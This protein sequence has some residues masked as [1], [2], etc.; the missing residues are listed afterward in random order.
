MYAISFVFLR[1]VFSIFIFISLINS[2]FSY[3]S[4]KYPYAFKLSNKN[5]FVIHE[6]GISICDKTFTRI[7][8]NATKFSEQEKIKSNAALSK[9]TSIFCETYFIICLI[10]DKIYIFDTEGSL[11]K[12]STNTIASWTV[13]YYSLEY[14]SYSRGYLYFVIGFISS[15]K[16]YLYYYEFYVSGQT[17][18]VSKLE[19]K[20][21]YDITS[22]ELSCHY[23]KHDNLGRYI[24]TC[25]YGYSNYIVI[26]YFDV[27]DDTTIVKSQAINTKYIDAKAEVKYIKGTLLIPEGNYK[28]LYVGYIT[29]DGTPYHWRYNINYDID[30]YKIKKFDYSIC[31]SIHHG[32]KYIYYPEKAELL[33]TCLLESD[34]WT[35]PKANILVEFLNQNEIQ[36]NYTYKFNNCNL[37][38]YS[39]IYLDS[40]HEY[41]IISDAECSNELIPFEILFEKHNEVATTM[42]EKPTTIIPEPTTIIPEP[43]TIITPPTTIIKE[44]TTIIK[45]PTTIITPP[46]TI[47][48]ELTTIITSPSTIIKEPTTIIP[49]PTTIVNKQTTIIN[50]PSTIIDKQTTIITPPSTILN[51]PTTIIN[52]PTTIINEPTTIIPKQTTIIDEPTTI[53]TQNSKTEEKEISDCPQLEKC[54]ICNEESFNKNLCIKCNEA[55]GYYFLNKNAISKEEIGDQYID[56]VNSDTKPSKFYFNSENEDYRLCFETCATCDTGGD[57]EI[58][59]CT[60]CELNYIFK[61]DKI[62]E[63]NCVMEC[64][65]YY[66][67]NTNDQYKCTKGEYCPL[68]YILLIKDK[69]KCTNDCKNDDP[70]RYQYDNHCLKECPINT[71]A[72]GYICKDKDINNSELTET[73]H[74]L[75]NRNITEDEMHQLVLNYKDNFNY[76]SNHI[77]IYKS[78]NYT[79]AIYK[80]SE[81][82]SSLSLGI[83]KINFESCYEK[84]KREYNISDDLITLLESE[85]INSQFDKIEIFS[86]YNPTTGEKIIFNDL[87]KSEPVTVNEDLGNKI[88]NIDWFMDLADQGI[89][90]FN[91]NSDFFTDL[92]YH[93]KSPIDGKDIPLKERFKLF[94]PNVSLCEKGCS[95]KGINTTTNTSIC[96]CTLNNIINNNFLTDNIFFQSTMAE[97]KTLIQ[98]SNIE[99]L[100]CYKDL[101]KGEF[102]RTNYGSFIILG[103]LLIQIILTIIYYKKYIFSMRKYLFNLIKTYLSYLSNKGIPS[104]KLDNSLD[105]I[106]DKVLKFQANP[107]KRSSKKIITNTINNNESTKSFNSNSKIQRRNPNQNIKSDV[108]RTFIESHKGSR[109]E[110]LTKQRGI[111]HNHFEFGLISKDQNLLYIGDIIDI[112]MEEY[113]K[114]DPDDMDYDNAIKRDTRTFCV[115]LVDNVKTDL[116]ILNIFCNYEQLNP[117][118][119]KFLLFI[120]NIDL[121]FFVNG[122][123]F[124]EDYLSELLY[125]KNVNFL[126]Y[127][128][129]FMER[130]YYITLVGII[131]GYVMNCFFFEERIIKKLFKREKNNLL[132]LQYEMS[133]LIKNIKNRYNSFIIICFVVAIFVWYYVFCFNNIYPSM[134]KEW[135]ITSVILIFVMQFIYFL[136]LLLETII[137][138][139][140]IKCKSERLF[141]FSQFLS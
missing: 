70:Y 109:N 29:S 7:I 53:I 127:A 34:T 128:S 24:V 84:I 52:E 69:K 110:L 33:Y 9:V 90:V 48:K 50:E 91:P 72:D 54:E 17:F 60:T 26:D 45:E 61:P 22:E 86:V 82:I 101:S 32:F 36:T 94:F 63:I 98:D 80:N 11:V 46:T 104:N 125:D 117:W 92:C 59:N 85:K 123:F 15:K 51:Q 47:I 62:P 136:K 108:R 120:L 102:Y 14:L 16:L 103:L 21:S 138:F 118:P 93:Y 105:E 31:E 131:I 18:S 40:Q 35:V 113:I 135:I 56:C 71:K 137:R 134:K 139:I 130:L 122:L 6:L 121:Y 67:Y 74:T 79:I 77:S 107:P 19:K 25:L 73:F 83:P 99:V 111:S 88:D 38:A 68:N 13:D 106:H 37:N 100:R 133:Q 64:P 4:F 10:N 49:E 87:C 2:S 124:T 75:F 112:D 76:T 57:W 39:I 43:T 41:F 20:N 115:Y 129:R 116:L 119:I 5:I 132:V 141:K 27:Y 8:F 95:I 96:E 30:Q 44:P 58:N 42:V 78:N 126:D 97:I 140:A 23:M 1:K 81:T 12:K 65:S 89:D 3:L 28:T 55:K 114:T 66:Y